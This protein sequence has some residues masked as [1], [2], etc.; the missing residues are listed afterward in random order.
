MGPTSTRPAL[1]P[2]RVEKLST[3]NTHSGSSPSP[4]SSAQPVYS[5]RK[6]A[7]T[8]AFFA[9]RGWNCTPYAFNSMVYFIIRPDRFG[10]E[11]TDL[12]G[13]F[14]S[15]VI[16]YAWKYD[17]SHLA[18]TITARVNFSSFCVPMFSSLECVADVVHRSV[19]PSLTS[20]EHRGECVVK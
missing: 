6:S 11:N 10:F 15:T 3:C 19:I 17:L 9:S 8:Y 4:S 16:E 5:T 7:M 18:V 14:I 1:E 12:S 2:A 20:N 13:M